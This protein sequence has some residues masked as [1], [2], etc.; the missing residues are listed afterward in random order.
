MTFGQVFQLTYN[1]S[2][3][4]VLWATAMA[5]GLRLT[6]EQV[7]SSFAPTR[8]MIKALLLNLAVIPVGVWILTRILPVEP[9]VA[10]GLLLLASAAGGPFGLT[11]TQLA[12]GDMAFALA[13]A[14]VLQITRIVAIPFW[15]GV[16]SPFGL[17][18]IF[19][20][21]ATLVLYILLPLAVGMTL[22]RFWR[23]RSVSW[24]LM[25]QRV[26]NALIVVVIV[27]ALLL[28][29]E[30][31]AAL[32]VSWIML[33]ILGIQ[34]LSLGLGYV[35]G[36]PEA[37]GRSAVAVTAAVRSSAVALIIANQVYAAQPFVAETVITYGVTAFVVATLAAMGLAR[38]Q[39]MIIATMSGYE[40]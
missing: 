35:S 31:L 7:A 11:A 27:S 6:V 4:V 25:I 3:A 2:L 38:Q 14:S 32:V 20:T 18:E 12:H 9:G 16:F 40:T 15:L 10:I 23:D 13:L 8:L 36:G 37:A 39:R 22:R 30:T 21:I 5:I 17:T 19:Q 26:G 29:H 34:L 1:V 24:S 33:L 28:Y